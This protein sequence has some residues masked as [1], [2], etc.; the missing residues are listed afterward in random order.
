MIS[1]NVIWQAIELLFTHKNYLNLLNQQNCSILE[2]SHLEL[3][4]AYSFGKFSVYFY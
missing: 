1:V 4:A 2:I 3:L